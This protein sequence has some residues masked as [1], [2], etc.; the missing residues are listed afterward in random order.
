MRISNNNGTNID[1]LGTPEL[2]SLNSDAI[3]SDKLCSVY[4][5]RGKPI[6]C[7]TSNTIEI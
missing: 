7:F 4:K 2:F 1:P 5:I 3:N 6:I